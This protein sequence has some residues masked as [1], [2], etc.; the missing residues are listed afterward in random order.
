M[1]QKRLLGIGMLSGAL[2]CL[3]LGGT[4]RAAITVDGQ[5]ADW[6]V[7]PG[8]YGSSD[9]TPGAGIYFVQED[10]NPAVDFQ[11][12]GWGGQSFDAEGLYYTRDTSNIY[13]AL[14]SGFPLEG[15]RYAGRNYTTGD[16]AFDFGSDGSYEIGVRLSGLTPSDT[17]AALFSSTTWNDPDPFTQSGP[18]SIASGILEGNAAFGYDDSTYA[19]Y[20]HNVYEFSIPLSLLAGV[21]DNVF[22][23]VSGQP[24][25]TVHWTMSCG[26]D[27]IDLDVT[28]SPEPLSSGLLLIG[29]G[30]LAYRNRNRM[31]FKV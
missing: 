23:S 31:R 2:L 18:L 16:L 9:W 10:T 1:L 4:A 5:L 13:V 17:T 3:T 30:G 22:Y 19:A 15:T 21:W 24:Q 28:H 20:N 25:F 11:N 8:A 14:V 7:N 26:N 29:L 27:A 12:P 6:G